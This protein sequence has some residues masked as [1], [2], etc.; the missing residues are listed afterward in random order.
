MKRVP[1]VR[2]ALSPLQ[3][4]VDQPTELDQPI[5]HRTRSKNKVSMERPLEQPVAHRTRSR[6]NTVDSDVV[7]AVVSDLLAV[8]VMDQETG[9]MLEF[10]QLRRHP[11]YK[12]YG[13]LHTQMR[14][15]VCV[16]G[17]DRRRRTPLSSE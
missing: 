16:R 4:R 1:R 12:K 15:V 13:T 10:R 6:T 3:P 8:S 17:S 7:T 11:K 9:K 14:L 5:A 2:K